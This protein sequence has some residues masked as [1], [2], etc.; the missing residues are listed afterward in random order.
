MRTSFAFV[1][2]L[3]RGRAERLGAI[4]RE[5]RHHRPLIRDAQHQP[6]DLASDV[7]D[8][9]NNAFECRP[10]LPA[11][12]QFSICLRVR[13]RSTKSTKNHSGPV[14]PTKKERRRPNPWVWG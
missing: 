4:L 10:Q 6:E 7:F 5:P 12:L 9:L 11:D 8:L 2:K 14:L 3:A 13:L 1:D